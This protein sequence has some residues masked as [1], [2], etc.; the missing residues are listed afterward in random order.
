MALGP[1]F[2]THLNYIKRMVKHL[3]GCTVTIRSFGTHQLKTSIFSSF[4]KLYSVTDISIRQDVDFAKNESGFALVAVPWFP[5]KSYY[6]LY[7]L[8]SILLYLIDGSVAGFTHGGHKRVRA[9]ITQLILEGKITFS[10]IELNNIRTVQSCFSF[11]TISSGAN[12][13]A[14]F[15]L[16]NECDESIMKKLAEYNLNNTKFSQGWNLKTKKDRLKK[17]GYIVKEKIGLMDVFYLYRIKANYRD[18]DYVDFENEVN[19]S[20]VAEYMMLYYKAYSC[21]RN[22]LLKAIATS[23]K[24]SIG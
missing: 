3:D 10:K 5:V 13:H 8:E 22:M 24:M 14:S 17:D 18:M 23:G 11:A 15:W 16:R 9:R 20:E 2:A 1:A 6:S 4:I 7:Y 21:Y 19:G 12:T